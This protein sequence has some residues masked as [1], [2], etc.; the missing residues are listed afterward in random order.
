M[1]LLNDYFHAFANLFEHGVK[2]V[3]DFVVVHVDRSHVFMIAA[4]PKS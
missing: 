1:I 3:R 4:F 2:V